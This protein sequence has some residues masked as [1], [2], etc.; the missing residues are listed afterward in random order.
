MGAKKFGR[1]PGIAGNSARMGG[2]GMPRALG[3]PDL[4]RHHRLPLRRGMIEC[5]NKAIRIPDGFDEA[6]D[7]L[8]VRIVDQV[9]EIIG[10][11][12][13]RFVAGRDDVS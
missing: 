5:G 8:G 1:K 7:H 4:Q 2:Y 12:Q 13:Y 11:R 9:F 6:A 3:P 10:S